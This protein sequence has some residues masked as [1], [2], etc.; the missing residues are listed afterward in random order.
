MNLLTLMITCLPSLSQSEMSMSH[1]SAPFNAK[2]INAMQCNVIQISNAK[3]IN[4]IDIHTFNAKSAKP[5]PMKLA[6][7]ARPVCPPPF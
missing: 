2:C 4:A 1:L 3:C 7:G 5:E 6:F